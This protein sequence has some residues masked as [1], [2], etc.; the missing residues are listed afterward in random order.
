M[1]DKVG[2]LEDNVGQLEDSAG[3]IISQ[4]NIT[5]D[6]S[7]LPVPDANFRRLNQII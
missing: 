6:V 2:Q 1:R 4:Y 5:E 7:S 3:N